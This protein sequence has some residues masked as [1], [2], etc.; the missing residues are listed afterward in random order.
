[1]DK[2]TA[3]WSKT[4]ERIVTHNNKRAWKNDGIGN[5]TNEEVIRTYNYFRGRCAYSGLKIDEDTN[6]SLEH[7]IP[8]ISG[9]HSTSFNCVPVINRYNSS[10]S[11]YHLLDWWKSQNDGKGNTIYNP[12]RLLKIV[13]YILKSLKTIENDRD[14]LGKDNKIDEYLSQVEILLYS[15]I[16]PVDGRD[17][18]KKLSSIEVI[19]KA[20]LKT[21]EEEYELFDNI[22]SI[23]IDLDIF[24]SEAIDYIKQDIKDIEIIE[25]LDELFESIGEVRVWDKVVYSKDDFKIN[26]NKILIEWLKKNNIE[27][28]FGI[29]GY[30]DLDFLSEQE[31]IEEFLD[32]RKAMILHTIGTEETHFN[33]LIN[34]VPNILTNPTLKEDINKLVQ[35][36]SISNK[37]DDKGI[38]ELSRYI[39]KKP[40]LLFT[41][42]VVDR[43]CKYSGILKI[44]KKTLKRGVPLSIMLENLETILDIINEAN[45]EVPSDV[46][47]RI[48]EKFFDNSNGNSIRLAYENL[49]RRVKN[50]NNKLD[51]EE[52][53]KEA[54]RWIV[55]ISEKYDASKIFKERCIG[56]AK[57]LYKEMKF[58]EDGYMIGV[59]KNA[60]YVPQIVQMA[61]LDI[62]KEAEA[63]LIE[64]IF[65]SNNVRKGVNVNFIFDY[66]KIKV[67]EL[68]P[69]LNEKKVAQEAARWLI[70]ISENAYTMVDVLYN[71][72][73]REDYINKTE[74]YYKQMTFDERGNYINAKINGFSEEIVGPD[75]MNL[76]D[77]FFR[78]NGK[79]FYISGKQVKKT[80]VYNRINRELKNC[81][82]KKMVREVC[83]KT[84][85][86]MSAEI[87]R[88]RR[89]ERNKGENEH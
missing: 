41:Q 28:V 22:G 12:Y 29:A 73:K 3:K 14:Y 24:L 42:E 17:S 20:N 76:V 72:E 61:N 34:K 18:N 11:G 32:N 87:K 68:K 51:E 27:N 60:Y 7:I 78:S 62:P 49:K 36:F 50:E 77:R 45:L 85:R 47:K 39:F 1:M 23:K 88:E 70:F 46:R 63:I 19:R 69:E 6:F 57:K 53:T 35:N 86:I 56:K 37:P 71:P 13:N 80:D 38:S 75:F 65:T 74:K 26:T 66:L 79:Y 89:K 48:I 5:L 30:S 9:G 2:E 81:K 52:I 40:E 54:A 31:N 16:Q 4:F 64:D 21:V 83:L 84:L 67:R 33:L 43:L 15:N 8:I 55:C 25:Y 44:D 82:N 59:N 10:K 58:D